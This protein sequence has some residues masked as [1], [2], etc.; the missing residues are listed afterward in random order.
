MLTMSRVHAVIVKLH[1]SRV[2]IRPLPLRE[3][4][5]VGKFNGRGAFLIIVGHVV[6]S[7]AY[8]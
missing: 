2:F 8:G 4:P 1:L 3:Q 5:T 6:D 7:G